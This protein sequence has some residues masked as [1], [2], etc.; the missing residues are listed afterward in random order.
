MNLQR[1]QKRLDEAVKEYD[2][3]QGHKYI[4]SSA[5]NVLC[6]EYENN[7]AYRNAAVASV[8]SALKD[9][10]TILSMR[11]VF[12]PS[13]YRTIARKVTDRLYDCD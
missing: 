2:L 10:F 8:E 13:E 6:K 1:L 11:N 9:A 12:E 3:E 7:K 5:S 4:L